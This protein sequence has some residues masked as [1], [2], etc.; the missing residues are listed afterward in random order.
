MAV[1]FPFVRPA[2]GVA[3]LAGAA[4][5]IGATGTGFTVRDKAYYADA[6]LVNFV[7]PGLVIQVTGA[8]I[9][10][11]GKVTRDVQTH[12]PQGPTARPVG[13]HDSR[14]GLRQLHS[15]EYP[16][17]ADAVCGLHGSPPKEPLSRA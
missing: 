16:E 10:A 13:R 1:K 12:R 6:N 2:V 17:G 8:N 3:V 5:L 7:R 15:G 14:R 11:D 4:A 9:A